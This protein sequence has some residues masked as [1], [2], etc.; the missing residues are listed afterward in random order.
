MLR[1]NDF[2]LQTICLSDLA[3]LASEMNA[4]DERRDKFKSSILKD[5]EELWKANDIKEE[6]RFKLEFV[7]GETLAIRVTNAKELL[8]KM[9]PKDQQAA[10]ILQH[11]L[12]R[13]G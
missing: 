12:N 10:R 13:L 4:K 6:A 5:M 3:I 9:H 7:E 11:K 1:L 8:L 2:V